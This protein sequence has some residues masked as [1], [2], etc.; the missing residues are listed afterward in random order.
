MSNQTTR[1]QESSY[2]VQDL[3][4]F[5]PDNLLKWDGVGHLVDNSGITS[6]ASGELTATNI[7]IQQDLTVNGTINGTISSGARYREYRA[8]GVDNS[9]VIPEDTKIVFVTMWGAGGGGGVN[10][11]NNEDVG[12]GGGGGGAGSGIFSIPVRVSGGETVFTTVGA[13]GIG[14]T[15]AG[16]GTSGGN[17]IVT[18]GSITLTAYGGAP[19]GNG[20]ILD[21]DGGG[22]GGTGAQATVRAGGDSYIGYGDDGAAGGSSNNP[23]SLPDW[24]D[25]RQYILGTWRLGGSSG[26]GGGNGVSLSINGVGGPSLNGYVGGLPGTSQKN[27]GGGGG[28]GYGGPGAGGGSDGGAGTSAAD[29]S[30]AGGGGASGSPDGAETPGGNGGSGYIIIIY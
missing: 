22:G 6:S 29:N 27:Y 2:Y 20:G 8:S 14:S 30:G 21:G 25:S 26:G 23:G 16:I 3:E 28:A 1:N 24:T 4:E 18:I 11:T 17:T 7:T 13:G 15:G 19:G 10:D 5:E 9:F 12:E